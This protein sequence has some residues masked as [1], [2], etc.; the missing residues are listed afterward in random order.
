[1]AQVSFDQSREGRTLD[2]CPVDWEV[3]KEG[4]LDRYFPLYFRERFLM[5][6]MNLHQGGMIVKEYSLKFTQHSMYSPTMVV[7]PRVE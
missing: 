1:M 6:F 3:V 4:I 2:E 5:K 7:D